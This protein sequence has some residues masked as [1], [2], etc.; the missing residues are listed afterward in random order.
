M[1]AM[2]RTA[3]AGTAAARTAAAGGAL[4]AALLAAGCGGRIEQAPP[5]TVQGCA[6]AGARAIEAHVTLLRL[7]GPCRGLS[8]AQVNLAVGKAIYMTAS[9]WPKAAWRRL[10]EADAVR[11]AHLVSRPA[12]AARPGPGSLVPPA[13]SPR[14]GRAV[15]DAALISW[16][17]AAASGGYLLA[18]WLAHGGSRRR[19]RRTGS[20]APAVVLGHAGLAVAGLTAW[21]GYLIVGARILAWVAVGLLL[22]VSGLGMATLVIGLPFGAARGPAAAGGPAAIA[23][24]VPR[25][26]TGR[27]AVAAGPAAAPAVAGASPAAAAAGRPAP[28]PPVLVI[29]GHG[30]LATLTLLLALLAAIGAA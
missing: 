29:A 4:L 8:R 23:A 27:P 1:T 25:S 10:A 28:R 13:A 22:P 7:P 12:P 17:L 5:V 16:L 14:T 9:G 3:T 2:A 11:L 26:P 15:A 6:T 24:T 30:A 21:A 18:S 19:S 20:L